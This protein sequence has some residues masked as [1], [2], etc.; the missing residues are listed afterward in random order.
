VTAV[1]V[2]DDPAQPPTLDLLSRHVRDRLPR[3][4]APRELVLLDALPVLPTGKPDLEVLRREQSGAGNVS[5]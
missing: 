5:K 2:P 3:Y 1:I 4:A